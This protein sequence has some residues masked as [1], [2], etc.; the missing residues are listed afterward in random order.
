MNGIYSFGTNATQHSLL[1]N[2]PNNSALENVIWGAVFWKTAF[3][4][5]R[6]YPVNPVHPV[7]FAFPILDN[8]NKTNLCLIDIPSQPCKNDIG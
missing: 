7:T 6:I 2:R 4:G 5:G 3:R 8:K 1:R